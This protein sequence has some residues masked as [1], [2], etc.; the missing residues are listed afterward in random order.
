MERAVPAELCSSP[1]RFHPAQ[2][3]ISVEMSC[4]DTCEA[5]REH[6]LPVITHLHS[7]FLSLC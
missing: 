6:R 4:G 5:Q 7:S 3:I 2:L 1:A